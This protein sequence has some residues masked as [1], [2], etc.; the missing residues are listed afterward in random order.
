MFLAQKKRSWVVD[1]IFIGENF[2]E[3]RHTPRRGKAWHVERFEILHWKVLQISLFQ[4]SLK[5]KL[6]AWLGWEETILKQL[7]N[8]VFLVCFVFFKITKDFAF[9]GA[10][11]DMLTFCVSAMFECE[12]CV[13]YIFCTIFLFFFWLLAYCRLYWNF[14]LPTSVVNTQRVYRVNQ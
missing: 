8:H 13:S 14:D 3:H 11:V 1:I 5:P 12:Q 10:C 6:Y 7:A 9:F 4:I 2:S